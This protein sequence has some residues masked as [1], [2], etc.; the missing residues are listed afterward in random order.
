MARIAVNGLGR[1]GRAFLKLALKRPEL[2]V[3]AVNDLADPE[4]LAYLMRFD[5]AYGRYDQPVTFEKG[6]EPALRIGNRRI[7]FLQER[8]PVQ[9]PWK[10]LDIDIVVEATGVFES[11]E[12]A[13]V[14]IKA[15]ARRVVLTAP[16]KDEDRPDA[17]TAL[18]GINLDALET[19]TLSSNAS[20]TTNSA[21]PVMQVLQET[22]GVR[23]AFLM[24]V[25]G[26][27]ATQQLVDGP[28]KGHDWRRG[29]AAAANIVP[30]TTGAAIAVARA[31][32][33]LQGR[34]DG[35]AMRVPVL[36]GSIS[37]IAFLS[38]RR[39]SA[40]EINSHLE[41]AARAERWN[42]VLTVT[43]EPIVSSDIVGD[44]HAAIVDLSLTKVVD[45]DF[46]SVYSWYDNEAG[47][48]HSLVEQVVEAARIAAP[49]TAA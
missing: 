48:A 29:R 10:A 44:S 33:S 3:M 34:F 42:R 7:R 24:T 45:G 14:H 37:A 46:C 16:A 5:S 22:I 38:E 21:S 8:D 28:V 43:R 20:C 11:F 49:R 39:T 30:S 26:Y 9:L 32:P 41:E 13:R 31:I 6:T 36:T 19:S 25:H 4:N 18:V 23:K 35:M 47:Y 12:K 40:E 17:R 1:I 2:E 27:T 15:G